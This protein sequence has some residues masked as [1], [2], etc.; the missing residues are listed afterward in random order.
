MCPYSIYAALPK[1]IKNN[2]C[3]KYY[4]SCFRYLNELKYNQIFK[5]F[6]IHVSCNNKRESKNSPLIPEITTDLS[7]KVRIIIVLTL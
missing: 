4:K 3:K 5:G 6:N 1:N 2:W 7:L